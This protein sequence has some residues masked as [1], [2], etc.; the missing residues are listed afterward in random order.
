VFDRAAAATFV[1]KNKNAKRWFVK[2]KRSGGKQLSCLVA[3]KA[4]E[5]SGG[6]QVRKQESS[7]STLFISVLCEKKRKKNAKRWCVKVHRDL[8]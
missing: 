1:Y 2:V 8:N 7:N 3:L 4:T 5:L 6:T